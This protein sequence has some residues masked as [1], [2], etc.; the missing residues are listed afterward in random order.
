MCVLVCV[1]VIVRYRSKRELQHLTPP[2][3]S[4]P[5]MRALIDAKRLLVSCP[6]SLPQPLTSLFIAS[7]CSSFHSSFT[8]NPPSSS[9]FSS[10]SF[11]YQTADRGMA[12]SQTLSRRLSQN[13]WLCN[14]SLA[15]WSTSG[16][17]AYPN[18][19]FYTFCRFGPR[20]WISESCTRT[21]ANPFK[22]PNYHISAL[23]FHEWPQTHK[24]GVIA[25]FAE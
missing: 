16:T 5:Y 6:S 25:H 8:Y 23:I 20:T 14:K 2:S 4:Y 9:S 10:A 22:V 24:T 12:R 19:Q 11:S 17:R 18:S 15:H 21:W 1:C 7:S 13:D 3:L